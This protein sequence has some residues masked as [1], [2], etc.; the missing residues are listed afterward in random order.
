[1]QVQTFQSFEAEKVGPMAP[2]NNSDGTFWMA[3]GGGEVVKVTRGHYF[4]KIY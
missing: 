4:A 2:D 1:M 3:I